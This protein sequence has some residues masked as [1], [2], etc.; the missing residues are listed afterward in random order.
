MNEVWTERSLVHYGETV[1]HIGLF[2]VSNMACK[3]L[4]K[5]DTLFVLE[6]IH[7]GIYGIF[8]GET[9]PIWLA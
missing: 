5:S 1:E 6:P 7:E 3:N 2:F 9:K 4:I 8:L